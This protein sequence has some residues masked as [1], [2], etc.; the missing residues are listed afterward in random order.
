M[1]VVGELAVTSVPLKEVYLRDV[2]VVEVTLEDDEVG[3]AE[4]VPEVRRLRVE[5]PEGEASAP[6]GVLVV[7]EL[8]LSLE[9]LPALAEG[10]E[11]E[12][13][14]LGDI[15]RV[16]LGLEEVTVDT[17]VEDPVP[18]LATDVGDEPRKDLIVSNPLPNLSSPCRGSGPRGRCPTG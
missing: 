11:V 3:L 12:N 8:A 7:N 9:L 4:S 17:L 13:I 15:V 16:V 10:A 14:L 18:V 2:P 5:V 6:E 1:T